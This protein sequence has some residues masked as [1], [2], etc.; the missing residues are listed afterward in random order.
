MKNYVYNL[1]TGSYD[2]PI[3]DCTEI[4]PFYL[5]EVFLISHLI[6]QRYICVFVKEVEDDD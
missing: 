1:F 5:G 3:F 4:F 2:C 6:E